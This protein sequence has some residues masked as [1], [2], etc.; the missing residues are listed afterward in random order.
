MPEPILQP[1]GGTSPAKRIRRPRSADEVGREEQTVGEAAQQVVGP[2]HE[3]KRQPLEEDAADPAAEIRRR[4]REQPEHDPHEQP[5]A[6]DGHAVAPHE[7]A[8]R[9]DVRGR[10]GPAQEAG[11]AHAAGAHGRQAAR[12]RPNLHR[13]RLSRPPK[14]KRT[15]AHGRVARAHVAAAARSRPRDAG[16]IGARAGGRRPRGSRRREGASTD[17]LRQQRR[18]VRDGRAAAPALGWTIVLLPRL[19]RRLDIGPRGS[20]P[21]RIVGMRGVRVEN[22]LF[23]RDAARLARPRHESARS[24]RRARRGARVAPRRPPR[25][26]RHGEQAR[27]VGV[28]PRP[29][30]APRHDPAERLLA[31]RRPRARASSTA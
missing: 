26:R 22:V 19:Y 20:R 8:Q 12:E 9:R 11:H 4:E 6:R 31:L 2:E 23:T 24:G 28:D 30:L 13:Q 25:P 21:L 10:R 5:V 29:R 1:D 15:P 3:R 7:R 18:R 27:A 14:L 17:D 16:P